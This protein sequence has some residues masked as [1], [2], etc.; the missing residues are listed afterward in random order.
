M[1][2]HIA[3][4]LLMAAAIAP[5]VAH[6]DAPEQ[7][8]MCEEWNRPQAPFQIYGNT[9]Y[10][11]TKGLSAVLVTSPDGHILLDGALIQ[12]AP[13]IAKNIEALG[14]RI[15]DVKLI[16]NSHAHSDHAGGIAALQRM[17]GAKVIASASGAKALREGHVVSDD[18]QYYP[19][20][21]LPRVAAVD[22]VGDGE[23]VSVGNLRLKAI[24]TPG[25]TPGGT[26]WTW[27]SCED[28]RCLNVVYADSL[29]A[30]SN[31]TFRFTGNATQPDLSASFNASIDKVRKLACDV[32]VPVH[33]DA[34]DL[35]ERAANRS[36][37]GNPFIDANSCRSYVEAPQK[38]LDKRLMQERTKQN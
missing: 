33:P 26:T 34:T 37:K 25:H 32:I 29:N 12:S 9:W 6:D 21:T 5:A 15:Q 3:A 16:L 4:A 14:F 18:P 17:S 28:G 30:Y 27:Q 24:Y 7:C 38:L 1:L 10:V 8:S 31:D 22:I 36:A 19:K 13:L 23:T 2:K 11:G 20:S 35:F